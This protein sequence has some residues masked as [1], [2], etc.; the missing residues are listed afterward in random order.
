MREDG[1]LTGRS[2][3]R[4]LLAT[5]A[6]VFAIHPASLLARPVQPE[7]VVRVQ[8][9]SEPAISPAGDL[10]AYTLTASDLAKDEDVSHIW[11]AQWDGSGARQLTFRAGE[12]ESTAKFSPDG[13]MI[14]FLSARGSD[15]D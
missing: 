4:L 12:S 9:V 15:D 14:G 11:L 2:F 5:S 8:G 3:M 7:D 6:L 13:K 1:L 10:V